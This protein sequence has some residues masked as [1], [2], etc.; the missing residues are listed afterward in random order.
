NFADETNHKLRTV[1]TWSNQAHVSF[2]NI[3]QLRRLIN[4]IPPQPAS[5]WRQ[6]RITERGEHRTCIVL[7]SFRHCPEF[8]DAEWP[9]GLADPGLNE[10][11]SSSVKNFHRNSHNQPERQKQDDAE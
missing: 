4:T 7:G 10:K 8:D 11:N 3:Q 5:Q 9:S 2:Q 1:G 6:P